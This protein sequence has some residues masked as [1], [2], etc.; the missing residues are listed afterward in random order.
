MPKSLLLRCLPHTRTYL[1]RFHLTSKVHRILHPQTPSL[2]TPSTGI[3]PCLKFYSTGYPHAA[4]R[5]VQERCAIGASSVNSY[6]LKE[7]KA[8]PGYLSFPSA[9]HFFI[10]YLNLCNSH[11]TLFL[12]CTERCPLAQSKG[13][14]CKD[15]SFK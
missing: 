12:Q 11:L 9:F 8:F 10:L 1:L 3:Y 15:C 6:T 5:R 14:N 13:K 4:H 7:G 2:G